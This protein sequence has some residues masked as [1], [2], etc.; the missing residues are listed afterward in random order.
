MVNYTKR[1]HKN[2]GDVWDVNGHYYSHPVQAYVKAYGKEDAFEKMQK[3][4]K[5]L[6]GRF[7]I[8]KEIYDK[9]IAY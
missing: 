8:T 4:D 9:I 5:H 3:V 6:F 7:E 2:G 1:L